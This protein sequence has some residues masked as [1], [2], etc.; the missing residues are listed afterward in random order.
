MISKGMTEG[1]GPLGQNSLGS[2]NGVRESGIR[3]A[4]IR[5][6]CTSGLINL[7]RKRNRKKKKKKRGEIRSEEDILHTPSKKYVVKVFG[8]IVCSCESGWAWKKDRN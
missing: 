3:C 7:G 6:I 1:D 8:A 2:E 5:C 4:N